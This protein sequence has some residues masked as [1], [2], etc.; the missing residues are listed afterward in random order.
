[1]KNKLWASNNV[2]KVINNTIAPA[3]ERSLMELLRD[4]WN[5]TNVSMLKWIDKI[6]WDSF[7]KLVSGVS[8]FAK[9]TT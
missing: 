2:E 5:E 3:F 4:Q 8:D 9:K 7:N 1:M 6:S